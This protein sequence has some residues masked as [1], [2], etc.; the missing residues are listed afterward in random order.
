MFLLFFGV[1]DCGFAYP[2]SSWGLELNTEASGG[3]CLGLRGEQI[4]L[5]LGWTYW[6]LAG[7]LS[8]LLKMSENLYIKS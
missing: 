6:V 1:T 8:V 4:P 7:P 3:G 5:S 2:K